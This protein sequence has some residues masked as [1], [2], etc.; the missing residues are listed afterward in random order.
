MSTFLRGAYKALYATAQDTSRTSFLKLPS[1]LPSYE[2][3]C[4]YTNKPHSPFCHWLLGFYCVVCLENILLLLAHSAPLGKCHI[5]ITS[6]QETFLGPA[7]C[8]WDLV[9]I[10]TV[11]GCIQMTR[12]LSSWAL[13][14]KREKSVPTGRSCLVSWRRAQVPASDSLDLA[15]GFS[16]QSW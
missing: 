4:F 10:P 7:V 15:L 5:D 9:L 14:S 1:L 13:C 2:S 11:S 8:P 6:S 12:S 3:A 16:T